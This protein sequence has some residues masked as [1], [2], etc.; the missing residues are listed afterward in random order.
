M[1]THTTMLPPASSAR[2]RAHVTLRASVCTLACAGAALL[3]AGCSLWSSGAD[4][5]PTLTVGEPAIAQRTD[6][7]D[8]LRF[9]V[10]ALNP[11]DRPLSLKEVQY[12][13]S[14]DGV[15]VTTVD[16]SPEA[17][18]PP[19][20][21]GTLSL[22]A[23]MPRGVGTPGVSRYRLEGRL[24]FLPPSRFREILYEERLA[25]PSVSFVSEGVLPA[26]DASTP[27]SG[28]ATAPP[29]P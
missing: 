9:P 10:D 19:F 17:T 27:G 3:P 23:A 13:L 6:A 1:R 4:E 5:T 2:A 7:G 29:A 20:A 14:V 26:A 22:P 12:T 28:A 8:V 18:L 15:P 25:A 16:R 21:P 11:T 24:I